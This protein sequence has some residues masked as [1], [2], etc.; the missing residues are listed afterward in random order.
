MKDGKK[1]LES[2]LF[3]INSVIGTSLTIEDVSNVIGL[4]ILSFQLILVVYNVILKI[5]SNY[6]NGKMEDN[7]KIVQ[8]AVNQLEDMKTKGRDDDGN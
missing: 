2:I 8:K 6:K 4:I 7:D 5:Y 1:I 3:V